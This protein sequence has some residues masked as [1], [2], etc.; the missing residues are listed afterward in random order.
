MRIETKQLYED[1]GDFII[2][3]D[4]DTG[5][6]IEVFVPNGQIKVHTI[7]IYYADNGKC[8]YKNGAKCGNGLI[9]GAMDDISNYIEK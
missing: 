8:F 3:V 4:P 6:E 2:Q 5:E 7:T 9:I 1:L